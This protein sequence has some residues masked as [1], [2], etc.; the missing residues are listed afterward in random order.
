M[1]CGLPRRLPDTLKEMLGRIAQI[2]ISHG[3]VPKH[4]VPHAMV[5]PLGVEGDAHAHPH[6]HGGLQQAILLITSEA[7]EELRAQG[8]AVYPGALGENVTT[9]GIDRRQM[10]A[11][12]RYRLGDVII[13]LTKAR[14]PC[15][16]L[17]AYGV[18]IQEAMYHKP[19]VK[20]GDATTATWGISGFYASVV[21]GGMIHVGA[22]IVL[23][24]QSA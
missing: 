11:G 19:A 24:D 8:F 20:A 5:H 3:G 18:G 13:E 17:D 21:R 7:I 2:N 6:I 9:E 15:N 10:L 16:Q 23:L 12:Q 14:A 4:P 22:P 1:Q